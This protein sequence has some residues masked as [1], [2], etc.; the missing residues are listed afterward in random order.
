MSYFNTISMGM[1]AM[2]VRGISEIAEL[3]V[4]IRRLKTFLLHEE[5]VPTNSG[6]MTNGMGKYIEASK[7]AIMMDNVCA[8][9]SKNNSDLALENVN[10]NV[11]RGYLL[12][13]IG[14]VGSGKSSLLQTI[15]GE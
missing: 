11:P 8:K 1:G 15:L 12:G 5:F 14:P 7:D 6:E 13:V 2:F 3:R 4:S 9:W 10:I